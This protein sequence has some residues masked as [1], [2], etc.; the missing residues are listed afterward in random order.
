MAMKTA[1]LSLLMVAVVEVALA[2]PYGPLSI[3]ELA[4]RADAVVVAT[5]VQVGAAAAP[6]Q[7]TP[8]VAASGF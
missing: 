5:P 1:A 4:N 7:R 2:G 3:E 8:S 6:P